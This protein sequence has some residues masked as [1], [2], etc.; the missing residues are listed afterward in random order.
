M[1]IGQGSEWRA[2]NS[3]FV[4]GNASQAGGTAS[5]TVSNQGVVAANSMRI[6][7]PGTL[8]GNGTVQANVINSGHVR[9]GN[10]A[11]VLDIVGNYTQQ[12]GAAL[13]IELGGI[14]PALQ[15]DSLAVTGAA[16]LGGT[17]IVSLINNFTPM[18]GNSFQILTANG[19]LTGTFATEVLPAL[20][21]NLVWQVEYSNNSILL[22]VALSGGGL[23]GDYNLDG[24][25][26]AADYVV[27]RKSEGTTNILPNDQL[28]GTI[29]SRQYN[30]WRA[31]FGATA[32]GAAAVA[33]SS[34]TGSDS[35]TVPEPTTLVF[36]CSS[37][38]IWTSL[39]CPTGTRSVENAFSR[40]SAV[41]SGPRYSG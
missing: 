36:V 12:V 31:N 22:G 19:G 28:G 16:T 20:T 29:D 23:P 11:G 17:L 15:Y 5:L 4:G 41:R 27:W 2:T 40:Y 14:T 7:S 9:P 26:D 39:R 18:A 3:L 13:E 30:Q 33:A 25:V 35:A 1:V 24:T 37:L 34:A 6:W 21:T 32:D 38:A 8:A 10:S